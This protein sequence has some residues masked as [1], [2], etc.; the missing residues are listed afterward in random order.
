M[1]VY[2]NSYR[3]Q[4]FPVSQTE[5][6]VEDLRLSSKFLTRIGSPKIGK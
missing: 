1:V 2:F 6:K 5:S 4:V 3:Y